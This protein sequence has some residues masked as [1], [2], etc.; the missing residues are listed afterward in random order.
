MEFKEKT[1]GVTERLTF[2]VSA[3]EGGVGCM[4]VCAG[5]RAVGWG[6]V[7]GVGDTLT[8]GLIGARPWRDRLRGICHGHRLWSF[9]LC[10]FRYIRGRI[11]AG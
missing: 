9:G 3:P 4:A 5:C 6:D 1:A 8:A 11:D 7:L 10:E 2:W